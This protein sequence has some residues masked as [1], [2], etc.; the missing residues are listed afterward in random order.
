[1]M[2]FQDSNTETSTSDDSWTSFVSSS[3]ASSVKKKSQRTRTA[4][5][6]WVTREPGSLEW[7]KGVMNEVAEMDHKVVNTYF[8]L[9]VLKLTTFLHSS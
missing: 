1:M 8:L 7:F 5:F 6:Y 4:H 2:R 3:T 9:D